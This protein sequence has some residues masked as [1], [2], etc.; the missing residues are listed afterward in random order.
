MFFCR[1]YAWKCSALASMVSDSARVMSTSAWVFSTPKKSR[2]SSPTRRCATSLWKLRKSWRKARSFSLVGLFHRPRWDY[3]EFICRCEIFRFQLTNLLLFFRVSGAYCQVYPLVDE[4]GRR[5][6]S[7]QSTGAAKFEV[8]VNVS[9][10][11]S[12]CK[13][14]RIHCQNSRQGNRYI[15]L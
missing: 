11:G 10:H 8:V 13:D 14:S 6:Q 9:Q 1:T 3:R 4:T 12:P 15:S 5:S 2:E 7:E